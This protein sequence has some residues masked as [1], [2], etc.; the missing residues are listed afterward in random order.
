MLQT[1]HYT[2]MNIDIQ[3]TNCLECNVFLT[4][5]IR[6]YHHPYLCKSCAKQLDTFDINKYMIERRIKKN[7]MIHN[8]SYNEWQKK[9]KATKGICPNCKKYIGIENLTI[10]H[11][12]PISKAKEGHIYNLKD[13][14]P[15]C[16]RC[17]SK[18]GAK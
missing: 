15:L 5:K 14:Q 3:L 7:K 8:F 16:K 13:V 10:D 4:E 18:K 17:N 6:H 11:I 2:K 12:Y 9:L 1:W